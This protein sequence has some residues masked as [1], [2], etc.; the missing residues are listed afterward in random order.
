MLATDFLKRIDAVMWPG[1][2]RLDFGDIESGMA[3]DRQP[4]HL[5]SIAGRD[6]RSRFVRRKSGDDEPNAVQ[7]ARFAARFRQNQMTQMNRV[8]RTAE[9]A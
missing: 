8:E 9:N 4:R 3:G 6:V 5:D 1:T 2:L 7:F